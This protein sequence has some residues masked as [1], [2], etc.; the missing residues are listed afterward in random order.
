[1]NWLIPDWKAVA[2]KAYSVWFAAAALLL[3]HASD[4]IML[5]WKVDTNPAS[6]TWILNWF[7]V[8]IIVSRFVPQP[9]KHKW[10]RRGLVLLFFGVLCSCTVPAMAQDYGQEPA[11]RELVKFEDCLLYTSDAA[12]E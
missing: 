6:W 5:A 10:K 7:L 2:A 3:L 1:M 4:F 11:A 8:A 9:E 12:D